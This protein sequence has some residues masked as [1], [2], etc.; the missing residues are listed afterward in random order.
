MWKNTEKTWE[1]DS[2][3]CATS[4]T[5]LDVLIE[6]WFW[7][8]VRVAWWRIEKPY[9][10]KYLYLYAPKSHYYDL[11]DDRWWNIIE[12]FIITEIYPIP[13]KAED[14]WKCIIFVNS[15]SREIKHIPFQ[16]V[17]W[18]IYGNSKQIESIK[19]DL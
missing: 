13:E 6:K 14:E 10:P 12:R 4:P 1:D 7:A 3:I 19:T 11:N 2:I 5:Q 18:R 17:Q 16:R 9:R 15:H 8:S